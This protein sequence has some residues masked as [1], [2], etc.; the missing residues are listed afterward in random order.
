MD[1]IDLYL[2]KLWEPDKY[3]AHD[4]VDMDLPEIEGIIRAKRAGKRGRPPCSVE[5]LAFHIWIDSVMGDPLEGLEELMDMDSFELP[6]PLEGLNLDEGIDGLIFDLQEPAS[7]EVP[8]P[9][10][11]LDF[12]KRPKG[13]RANEGYVKPRNLTHS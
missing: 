1:K 12:A 3:I 4:Y 2:A 7:F 13:K 11:G 10:E 5:S 8:D 9:L 6:D